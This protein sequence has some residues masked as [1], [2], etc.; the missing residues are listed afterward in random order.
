MDD[1]TRMGMVMTVSYEVF[2]KL[3]LVKNIFEMIFEVKGESLDPVLEC[4][5][6]STEKLKE[7]LWKEFNIAGM[8]VRIANTAV[9]FLIDCCTM[10]MDLS[11]SLVGTIRHCILMAGIYYTNVEP[12]AV[13]TRGTHVVRA[14]E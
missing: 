9:D 1:P 11:E 10:K 14:G 8:E 6:V 5:G 13:D 4:Y 12:N 3:P 7:V 2:M